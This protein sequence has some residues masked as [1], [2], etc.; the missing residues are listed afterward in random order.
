MFVLLFVCVFTN[1][2]THLFA[3]SK[4]LLRKQRL[5][6]DDDKVYND[7]SARMLESVTGFGCTCHGGDIVCPSTTKVT[8]RQ[9]AAERRRANSIREWSDPLLVKFGLQT[10]VISE[11]HTFS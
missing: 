9:P 1:K 4:H 10:T 3:G 5:H 8:H 11:T 7:A 6:P 2:I